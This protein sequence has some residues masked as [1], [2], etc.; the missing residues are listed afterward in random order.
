MTAW[1]A[2]LEETEGT[3]EQKRQH[4]D[5]QLQQLSGQL[6]FLEGQL[7]LEQRD[8]NEQIESKDK[9]IREQQHQIQ[10]LLIQNRHLKNLLMIYGKH[11]GAKIVRS[12]ITG[13]R[14]TGYIGK[15]VWDDDDPSNAKDQMNENSS[16]NPTWGSKSLEQHKESVHGVAGSLSYRGQLEKDGIECDSTA[17]QEKES[18]WPW[19]ESS[20][21]VKCIGQGE[22]G[23]GR[24]AQRSPGNPTETLSK[25]N[26]EHRQQNI[27][28]SRK[29]GITDHAAN[30]Q[31]G[32]S[33]KDGMLNTCRKD[34]REIENQTKIHGSLGYITDKCYM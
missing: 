19:E 4:W 32:S 24:D 16:E 23:A 30:H 29:N 25:K 13:N 1:K 10:K 3:L 9:T 26:A 5:H 17:E 27:D 33:Q 15:S 8:I 18:I 11:N 14:S 22:Q 28:E 20:C 31:R 7:R 34:M 21:N 12:Q 2:R 6:L